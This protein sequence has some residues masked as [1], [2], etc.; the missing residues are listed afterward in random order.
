LDT[1]ET[2]RDLAASWGATWVAPDEAIVA[3][4]D[5]LVPCTVGGILTPQVVDNLR[6]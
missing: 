5:V 4:V 3:D 6:P 1:D 2:K